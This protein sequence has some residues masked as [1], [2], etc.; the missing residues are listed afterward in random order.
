MIYKKISLIN[1]PERIICCIKS[2]PNW[3]TSTI[4]TYIKPISL[5][6]SSTIKMINKIII[7]TNYPERIVC[8]IE[9]YSIWITS[10]S[11]ICRKPIC[12]IISKRIPSSLNIKRFISSCSINSSIRSYT[13]IISLISNVLF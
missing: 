9:S 4:I 1:Y 12:L 3:S 7:S 8:W 2:Y 13:C 11:S 6:I 10:T 5:I